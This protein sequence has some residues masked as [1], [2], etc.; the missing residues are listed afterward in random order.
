MN[1][2]NPNPTKN[3]AKQN[4][5]P[6]NVCP[7]VYPWTINDKKTPN[8]KPAKLPIANRRPAAVPSATGKAI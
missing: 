1:Q 8:K 7:L 2:T 5:N 4:A 3:I 6:P